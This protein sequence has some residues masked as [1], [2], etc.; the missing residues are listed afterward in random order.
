[1]SG[2]DPRRARGGSAPDDAPA[3]VAAEI[4]LEL[5]H[6]LECLRAEARAAGRSEEEAERAAH[7]RFG[8][9]AAIRAACLQTRHP[10][11]PMFA[12][13]HRLA[14]V[15]LAVAVVVLLFLQHTAQARARQ[16]IAALQDELAQLVDGPAAGRVDREA[17]YALIGDTLVVDDIFGALGGDYAVDLTGTIQLPSLGD[18]GR[19][20][21]AGST[22]AEIERQIEER[23]ASFFVH[24]VDVQ[25]ALF[26]R[27]PVRLLPRAGASGR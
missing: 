15:A 8:D 3:D 24:T 13:I 14:T 18:A 12:S 7:A 17:P 19:L 23:A 26:G 27:D 10:G 22:P 1:V 6:H 9:L 16:Q 2:A 25:V 20:H 4:E 21:V 5:A 11:A